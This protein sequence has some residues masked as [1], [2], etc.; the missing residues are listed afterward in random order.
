[1]FTFIVGFAC[2]YFVGAYWEKIKEIL[3]NTLNK[4]S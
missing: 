2:G 1:M 4:V 3:K